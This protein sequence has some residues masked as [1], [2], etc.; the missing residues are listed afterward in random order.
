[1]PSGRSVPS[2]DPSGRRHVRARRS[3]LLVVPEDKPETQPW[4]ARSRNQE[5]ELVPTTAARSVAVGLAVLSA[6]WLLA[7]CSPTPAGITS[8]AKPTSNATPTSSGTPFLQKPPA[9]SLNVTPLPAGTFSVSSVT[10]VSPQE[11]W[12]LGGQ[13]CNGSFLCLGLMRTE[14]G[15]KTWASAT[16]PPTHLNYIEQQSGGVSQIRFANSQGGW[17]FDPE[18]WTTDDGGATWSQ[19]V[20][21]GVSADAIVASLETADGVVQAAVLDQASTVQIE[22]SP[23]GVDDWQV[24]ATTVAIGAGPAPM[25]QLV[26]Q[27][28]AGWLLENDRTVIGG[29]RLMNGQWVAWQPPC[30]NANGPALLAASSAQYL[31]AVCHQGEWGPASPAGVLAYVSTDGGGSFGLLTTSVPS[32]GSLASPTPRVLVLAGGAG[33]LATFDGGATWTTVCSAP[34]D[35]YVQPVGFETSTQGVAIAINGE[36]VIPVGTLLMTF[37]GGHDWSPVTL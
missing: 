27:G 21:P 9:P 16:S 8:S 28:S 15:G 32:Y 22:T 35:T 4:S 34:L 33:L 17:A 31:V 19:I 12:V 2:G 13:H 29:A 26:L 11:G 37:D 6:V 5:A 30:L 18:L 14:D 24:S 36:G 20:L 1:V 25:P 23:I 3:V 7:A 10:F